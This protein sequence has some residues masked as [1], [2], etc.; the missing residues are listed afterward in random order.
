ML[1]IC[2]LLTEK[3]VRLAEEADCGF[4]LAPE[5]IGGSPGGQIYRIV[6]LDPVE[7]EQLRL[8]QLIRHLLPAGG[9]VG[10]DE[11]IVHRPQSALLLLD[12]DQTSALVLQPA[13]DSDGNIEEM[14]RVFSTE[15]IGTLSQE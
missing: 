2:H 11:R 12:V 14:Q 15:K 1:F 10:A 6:C 9:E 3:R 8:V 4:L 5:V 7:E 13:K